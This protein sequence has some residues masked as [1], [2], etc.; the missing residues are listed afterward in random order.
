MPG[1]NETERFDAVII[2]GGLVGWAAAYALAKR[3]IPALVIDAG[4][5]GAAT[6]AGAGMITPGTSPRLVPAALP[7]AFGATTHYPQLI[8][9]L[10]DA[11]A[12]DTGYET[13]GAIYVARDESEVPS[14]DAVQRLLIE[15]RESGMSLIG[16]IERI[17]GDRARAL[18]PPLTP[19]APAAVW[20]AGGTRVN[21][22]LL[23]AAIR[24]AALQ[25]GCREQIGRASISRTGNRLTVTTPDLEQI[26]PDVVAISGGAWT[27]LLG[28]QV[29]L[30]LPIEPQK[31]QIVH[32][33]W[34]DDS[35]AHWPLLESAATHYML[36]FPG[37][38]IVAGATRELGQG[39]DTRVTAAGL[40]EVLS[41][42]LAIAP[43]LGN[44]EIVETRVGLRPWS[45]DGVPA[46]GRLT[47]TD[48]G[49]ICTG[50][51]PSGLTIGPY[52]AELLAQF[53]TK[54]N[55][56]LDPIPYS[57]DRWQ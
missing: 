41:E 10:A 20:F 28:E 36:G 40:H 3:S 24:A 53:I 49:W 47:G 56:N 42:A 34:Q 17:S 39:Y 22:R 26:D 1:M 46:I 37:G 54:E 19:E 33:A 12:G 23:R 2:G 50:H 51:G 27:P 25:L 29:G 30:N 15:R 7:L 13:V 48:N 6:M 16:E 9:A 52:S 31:G 57:P 18:F 11:Q 45:P 5:A 44:C 14:L 55:P 4:D 35:T 38:R 8:A 32:L 21:G 43:G